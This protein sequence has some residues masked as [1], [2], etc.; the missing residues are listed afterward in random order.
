M[1]P[2]DE[3]SE[4]TNQS[5]RK[6]SPP[7]N[8]CCA[9]VNDRSRCMRHQGSATSRDHAVLSTGPSSNI[10]LMS[11][12][13]EA[14]RLNS[15]RPR[16]QTLLLVE[17]PGR[18]HDRTWNLLEGWPSISIGQLDVSRSVWSTLEH[19]RQL[20]YVN[21]CASMSQS[22]TLSQLPEHLVSPIYSSLLSSSNY[23]TII[24][25]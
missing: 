13:Q 20:L 3:N 8:F 21:D 16:L 15:S 14:N 11:L 25:I 4:I 1:R 19:A 17:V 22:R 24:N 2:S 18:S 12:S 5:T 10:T 23:P 9:K 6:T 7:L